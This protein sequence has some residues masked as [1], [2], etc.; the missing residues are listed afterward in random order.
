MEDENFFDENIDKKDLNGNNKIVKIIIFIIIIGVLLFGFYLTYLKLNEEKKEGVKEEEKDVIVEGIYTECSDECVY[1]LNLSDGVK[2]LKY[3]IENEVSHKLYLEDKLLIELNMSCGGFDLLTV[4]DD[5]FI[6]S[7]NTECKSTTNNIII[8]NS[9]GDI[10]KNYNY[11]D[12]TYNMWIE[13]TE[14]KV[15][16]N[17]IV[18]N[19]TRLYKEHTLRLSK[20]QE[21]NLCE[22]DEFSLYGINNTTPLSG[23]YTIDYLGNNN[24]SE[25]KFNSNKLVS[26][27][28]LTC[29]E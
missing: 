10:L 19:A 13:N 6:I 25:L 7:Y 27:D 2:N 8:F 17:S 14:Y 20:N 3:V 16:N 9:K 18:F 26:D 24:F 22:N 28:V 5:I 23:V 12:N 15:I 11:V 29:K 4:L 21:V 1:H